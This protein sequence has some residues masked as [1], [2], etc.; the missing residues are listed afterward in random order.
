MK[1]QVLLSM[2]AI[3]LLPEQQA[4]IHLERGEWEV[5]EEVNGKFLVH[6]II[7]LS[8]IPLI[9]NYLTSLTY[10]PIII[11]V[12][13]EDGISYGQELV[14]IGTLET[15]NYQVQGTAIYSVNIAELTTFTTGIEQ[16][17]Q[18]GGWNIPSIN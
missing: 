1:V 6:A 16:T 11:G 17:H 15:P 8:T 2:Q 12:F 4:L 5:I 13:K 14:N 18:F 7:D 10:T 3:P 9:E